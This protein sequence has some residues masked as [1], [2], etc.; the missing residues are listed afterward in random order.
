MKL[1][2][3]DIRKQAVYDCDPWEKRC[4]PD[5]PYDRL[6]ILSESISK[7]PIQGEAAHT[8]HGSLA[9]LKRQRSEFE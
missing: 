8:K 6:S 4:K 7:V 3:S 2:F 1:S 9:E 5:E